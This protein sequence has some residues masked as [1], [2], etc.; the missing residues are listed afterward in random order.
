M[1]NEKT[2]KL[3]ED[4]Y[5]NNPNKIPNWNAY[6]IFKYNSFTSFTYDNTIPMFF[7]KT[8]IGKMVQL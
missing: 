5:Y 1:K 4:Y 8:L 7:R 2:I 6:Q 3:L